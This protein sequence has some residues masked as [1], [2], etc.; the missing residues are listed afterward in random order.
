[1]SQ[2]S[3][4]EPLERRRLLNCYMLIDLGTLGGLVS[5][6]YDVNSNDQVVGYSLTADGRDRAFRFEDVNRNGVADAGEMVDLGALAGDAA[7]YAWGIN[8][9]GA[10]VGTSRST[11]MPEESGVERAVRFNPGAAPTDLALGEGSNAFAINNRGQIAGGAAVG[12]R[13]LGF[14]RSAT[15]TVTSFEGGM[16][17]A[18][19]TD[20]RAIDFFAA[21][22]GFTSAFVGDSGFLRLPDGTTTLVG[23][24]SPALPYS[25]AWDIAETGPTPGGAYYVTG[26]GFNSAGEYHAFLYHSGTDAVTDLGTLPGFGGS[27]GYGVQ[28]NGTVVG[29]AE[30]VEGGPG[31]SHAFIYGDGV[32]RDL[33]DLL[34]HDSGWTLTEARAISPTGAIAGFGIAPDGA[35]RA[36]LLRPAPPARVVGR[37]VFYNNSAFDGRD[38][39][40][41]ELDDNAI[42]PDKEPLTFPGRPASSLN[43][44]SYS[45]GINGIMV[46]VSDPGRTLR[47]VEFEF[48]V[49]NSDDPSAWTPAPPALDVPHTRPAAG[50]QR[51]DRWTVTWPDRSIRNTWLQVTTILTDCSGEQ[52]RDVFYYGNLPGDTGLPGV[53][54]DLAVTARD[55][56]FTRL[57]VSDKPASIASRLDHNRDGRVNVLDVAAVRG[58]F[59][60]SLRLI[61]PPAAAPAECVADGD[62]SGASAATALLRE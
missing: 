61:S 33:N 17:G 8:D 32:M 43:V 11:P 1:M 2:P 48:R 26:E 5:Y 23:H 4:I 44:T 62:G 45:K 19:Y 58:N 20:V 12:I 52:A 36:F 55:L 59:S 41:N 14:I 40:A 18:A 50:E 54:T 56:V 46:D 31:P 29:R 35:T 57:A 13:S 9:A 21:A 37:H 24:P 27:A 39:S 42:P 47:D 34:P 53:A 3:L 6:A 38:R 7:S 51:G 15:G 28:G 30:P 16:P 60:A 49:G 25:Y 10:V 22:V